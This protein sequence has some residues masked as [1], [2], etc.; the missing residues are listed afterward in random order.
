MKKRNRVYQR[1][2]NDYRKFRNEMLSKDP[3]E[4]FDR[5]YK[6]FCITEF[7]SYLTDSYEL[8]PQSVSFILS[9]KGNVFE[10]LYYE[11]LRSDYTHREVFEEVIDS[12]LRVA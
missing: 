4:L 12:T 3:E 10:Q 1:L 2:D 6:V 8:T 11:W 5:A 9:Y 7:Y